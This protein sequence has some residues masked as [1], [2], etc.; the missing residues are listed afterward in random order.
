M[1]AMLHGRLDDQASFYF[2]D[3][4]VQFHSLYILLF[5]MTQPPPFK[6]LSTVK[7]EQREEG[8]LEK[9]HAVKPRGYPHFFLE[10]LTLGA[11]LACIQT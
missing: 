3:R 9:G 10:R 7:V 11:S 2:Y 4:P 5:R 6:P 1:A 8:N